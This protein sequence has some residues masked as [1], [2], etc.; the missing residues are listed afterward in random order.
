MSLHTGCRE[1]L[2]GYVR[3]ASVSTGNR[4]STRNFKSGCREGLLQAQWKVKVNTC[5]ASRQSGAVIPRQEDVA[6]RVCGFRE[7]CSCTAALQF[8]LLKDTRKH[9]RRK[10]LQQS[11][12]VRINRS[13]TL[14]ILNEKQALNMDSI[15][16]CRSPFTML[17]PRNVHRLPVS[18]L[19]PSVKADGL[20]IFT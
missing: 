17:Y 13:R 11:T 5:S 2:N 6:L 20:I 18:Q 9:T 1:T 7:L 14:T 8:A 10:T 4:V 19:H 12:S 15:E 3:L 16:T